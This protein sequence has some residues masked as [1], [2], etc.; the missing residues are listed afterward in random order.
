MNHLSLQL[1]LCHQAWQLIMSDSATVTLYDIVMIIDDGISVNCPQPIIM[2]IEGLR[3]GLLAE[4]ACVGLLAM[5]AFARKRDVISHE[6]WKWF[7]DSN[8]QLIMDRLGPD[9]TK[10]V[11]ATTEM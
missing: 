3:L 8:Y 9:R 10:S 4:P 2:L 7:V 1:N 6:F 5:G 11:L